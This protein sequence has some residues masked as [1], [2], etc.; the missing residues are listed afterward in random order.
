[1]CHA[2]VKPG[3][4][5]GTRRP[6]KLSTGGH[7]RT[8]EDT[9]G[10][11]AMPVRDYEALVKVASRARPHLRGQPANSHAAQRHTTE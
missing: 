6:A 9:K 1:M 8:R 5:Q 3:G 4:H 7:P 2:F 11:T 10:H